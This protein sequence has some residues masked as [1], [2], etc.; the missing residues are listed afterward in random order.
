M[1]A[2]GLYS[3]HTPGDPTE[4]VDEEAI[5]IVF[6]GGHNACLEIPRPR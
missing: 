5:E 3:V 1:Y 4:C 6:N 2:S